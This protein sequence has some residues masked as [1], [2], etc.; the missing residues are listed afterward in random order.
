MNRHNNSGK[1]SSLN[2]LVFVLQNYRSILRRAN[3]DR[4]NPGRRARLSP[5][6]L[7]LDG[8]LAGDMEAVQRAVKEVCGQVTT[9]AGLLLL[10]MA[11]LRY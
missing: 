5:L 11:A 6:V 2:K 9:P 4:R 7:L 10:P 8:A 3:R 1:A